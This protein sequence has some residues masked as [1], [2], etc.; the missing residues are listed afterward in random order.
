MMKIITSLDPRINRAEIPENPDTT[1]IPK[2]E[3]DQFKTFEVFH[4]PKSGARHLHVG[5]VH[6]PTP[7]LAIAFAKEQYARRGDCV[8]LWVVSTDD[9][10]ALDVR[11]SDIFETATQ[12][13]Y[14]EVNAYANT[15]EKIEAFKKEQLS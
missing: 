2:E 13:P 1:F 12:K 6:A 3:L 10:I 9:I 8:N 5:S 4:Q 7:E 14:R 15:R 11:F